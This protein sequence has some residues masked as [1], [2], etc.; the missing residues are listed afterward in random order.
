MRLSE[1]QAET[2]RKRLLWANKKE[3]KLGRLLENFFRL[4]PKQSDINIVKLQSTSNTKLAARYKHSPINTVLCIRIPSPKYDIPVHHNEKKP[5]KTD[6]LTHLSSLII[7]YILVFFL[8]DRYPYCK[9]FRKA[10]TNRRSFR[11]RWH[12]L[13]FFWFRRCFL[14]VVLSF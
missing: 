8:F 2:K 13:Q 9:D 14:L 3:K 4:Y 11:F 6:A 10:G 1:N 5:T 7:F 12:R